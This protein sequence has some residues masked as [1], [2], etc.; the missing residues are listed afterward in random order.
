MKLAIDVQYSSETA[1]V[2]AV[3]FD[4]WHAAMPTAE[5]T[6]VM[7]GIA[8][9][10]PGNFYKRELPCILQLLDQY[11]L[12]PKT[13]VVDGYVF[14]D[15][16]QKPGLGKHLYDALSAKVEV[17]GVAKQAFAG[18]ANEYALLRGQSSKP[19]YIT[20]INDLDDAKAYITQMY[21]EHRMPILLKRVDQ[22]CREMAKQL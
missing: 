9:Y 19:L 14:L 15:G 17:I 16:Q 3:A 6:C 2:A 18:I 10:E 11:Q 5:Y 7:Q 21:G 4:N 13:I 8:D 20:T 22:L 12:S 1:F